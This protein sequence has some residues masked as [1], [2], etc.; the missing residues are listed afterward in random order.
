[1]AMNSAYSIKLGSIKFLINLFC[2]F[3]ALYLYVISPEV[4]SFE[5]CII[6]MVLYVLFNIVGGFCGLFKEKVSFEFFFMI[7]FFMTNFVYPV[8]Y[9]IDNPSVGFFLF[10]FDHNVISKSTALALLAYSCYMFAVV[11]YKEANPINFNSS[12]INPQIFIFYLLLSTL[13]F[14][15]FILSGGVSYL[16][17]IYGGQSVA[18]GTVGL[19]SYFLLI[20]SY[21]N[22]LL[23]PFV[24][25][26]KSQK[27]RIFT[28]FLFFIIMALFLIVGSRMM[29]V[30]MLLGLLV[31]FN[32]FVKR[33]SLL[34]VSILIFISSIF[35]FFISIIRLMGESVDFEQASV[36]LRSSTSIFDPFMDLIINNRNLYVLVDH[37]DTHGSF[38]FINL[39]SKV[40]E[41][42]P[43]SNKVMDFI[44]IPYFMRNDF[45]TFLQ[46][47][48]DGANLG[49][50]SNMVGEAYLAF[51]LYG[52]I[53]IFLLVGYLIKFIKR[54][55]VN[56]QIYLILFFIIA[57]TSVLFTRIPP[58]LSF[59]ML[60]WPVIIFLLVGYM[61]K[62]LG[63]KI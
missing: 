26:L 34:V 7:A 50:G 16:R 63:K 44:G 59:K 42:L 61:Y 19:Y 20:F 14:M 60:F 9:Y 32:F 56:S 57:G 38:V 13:G 58:I 31:G 43:F 39:L 4:Y 15:G 45:T 35:L 52:V 6:L 36:E 1:M 2:V 48:P 40:L 55:A 11:D 12:N 21:S 46:F 18:W 22:T 37:V 49:L 41:I 53:F 30:S 47:G 5:F 51:G 33:I 24:W 27:I 54:R 10:P 23:I 3:V 17:S 29:V 25:S 8:F 62:A 28:L